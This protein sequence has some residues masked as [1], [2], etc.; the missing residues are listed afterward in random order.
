MAQWMGSKFHGVLTL[1]MLL[2]AFALGTIVEFGVSAPAGGIGAALSVLWMLPV[3]WFFCAK[4]C[5]RLDCGHV[6][7]GL[8]TRIL[9]ARKQGPYTKLEEAVA[10]VAMLVPAAWHGYWLVAGS[11][12]GPW[13]LAAFGALLV[14][15]AVDVLLFVCKKCPNAECPFNKS[16]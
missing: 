9:P 16:E 12:A 13:F 4:C 14:L 6:L 10:V 3:A 15:A 7:L 1:L 8:I 2:A 11:S 5:C